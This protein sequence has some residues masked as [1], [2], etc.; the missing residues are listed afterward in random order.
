MAQYGQAKR[1]NLEPHVCTESISFAQSSPKE[2]RRRPMRQF[3]VTQQMEVSCNSDCVT[4]GSYCNEILCGMQLNLRPAAHS[5][6]ATFPM[7]S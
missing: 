2:E 1:I 7:D 6:H 5:F 3:R 4:Y